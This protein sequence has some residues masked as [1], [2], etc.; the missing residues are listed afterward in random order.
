MLLKHRTN[1]QPTTNP[2]PQHILNR[3]LGTSLFFCA[4]PSHLSQIRNAVEIQLNVAGVRGGYGYDVPITVLQKHPLPMR[5]P[6]W[7]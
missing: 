7:A 3:F 6:V 4:L 2:K 1:Q 5:L